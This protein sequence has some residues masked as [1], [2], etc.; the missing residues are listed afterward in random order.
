MQGALVGGGFFAGFHM[1]AWRRMGNTD[2]VEISWL[3][4][5]DPI[6]A[7]QFGIPNVFPSFEALLESGQK[8]DFVDIA[9]RPDLHLPLTRMAAE[10]KIQVICQKPMAPSWEECVE[11]VDVCRRNGVRLLMHENWRWQPWYRE[12]KRHD[13]GALHYLGF[14]MRTGDGR[15]PTPYAAQPYFAQMPRLLIYETLVHFL[16]TAR[17]LMGEIASV[18]CQTQRLNPMIAGEDAAQIHL[19]FVSGATGVIDANRISGVSPS[20]VAFGEA[21]LEGADA[22]IRMSDTGDLWIRQN[23]TSIDAPI[24]YDKPE[25]GYKGDSILALQRHFLDCLRTGQTCESEGEDYLK[26]VRAVFACYESAATD[27]PCQL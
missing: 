22:R 5:P 26:T 18:Y 10:A 6:R 20:P 8:P 2:D 1:D 23:G 27:T 21:L 7:V 16:D 12:M 13:L 14:R 3:V 15:G 17:Y 25:I 11:M 19:R 24:A 9:T 4:E